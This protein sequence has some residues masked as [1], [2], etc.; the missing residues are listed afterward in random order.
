MTDDIVKQLQDKTLKELGL[1]EVDGKL[2]KDPYSTVYKPKQDSRTWKDPEGYK[3]L[4][5]WSNSVLLRYLGRKF[6]DSLPKSEYRRKAQLDDCLRSVVR[7]IEEGF[8][9]STTQEYTQFLGYSQG[10]LEEGKGD[11]KDLAQDGFLSS[12][13][14]SSLASLEIDLRNFNQALRNPLK[15]TR[16]NLK[17]FKGE[18]LDSSSHP[19]TSSNSPLK[20]NK[21]CLKDDKSWDW[22]PLQILYPPLSRVQASNLTIEIFLELINKTDYL[23]RSLVQS[24]EDKL[25]KDQKY[26]QVEKLKYKVYKKP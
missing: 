7:N 20:E 12:K 1:K 19:L 26:Y 22:K 11:I 17:D 14:G 23:L 5:P 3:Y 16:G 6:T 15:D 2:V 9:R 24:L 10:S 13:P 8:K 18:N 25:G 21:G 4:F